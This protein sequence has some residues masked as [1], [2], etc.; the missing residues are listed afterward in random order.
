MMITNDNYVPFLEGGKRTLG[1]NRELFDSKIKVTLI[2]VTYN[3]DKYLEETIKSIV[4]QSYEN[5]EYI[6]IDGGSIDQT[7]EIIERYSN[8]ID[9][10]IS[11]KDSGMY[12]ALNKGLMYSTGELIGFCNSDDILYS[13]DTIW[14]IVESYKKEKFDCCYGSV[15]Y[16]DKELNV[17]YNR[18]PLEFKPRY[19]ITLG[20]PFA[21]P[22]FFWTRKLMD[23]TGKFNLDYKIVGDYD[24]IGRL[25]LNSKKI[26]KIRNYLI[27]FRKHG[28]SFG[29][30]NSSLALE[31][32]LKIKQNLIERIKMNKISLVIYS[33]LDRIFQ[34]INQINS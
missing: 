10:Y 12:D 31:E 27:K 33:I 2:T 17:L 13:N 14:E 19:L 1:N 22:T 32:S 30:H 7:I 29:D 21:Q 4:N 28:D 15:Q 8:F 34:K 25:L 23:Q 16:V 9:Y 5:I 6:I 18:K 11:E 20:M 26:Y 3:S 24:L